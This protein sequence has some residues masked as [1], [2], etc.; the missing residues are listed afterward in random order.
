MKTSYPLVGWLAAGVL[1]IAGGPWIATPSAQEA[2][3]VVRH[4]ERLNDSADSPLSAAG[5]ARAARLADHLR[6]ARIT[7][8]VVTQFVRTADTAQPLAD[9]LGLPLTL[10]PAAQTAVLVARLRALGPKARVLVVGHSNT[11][12]DILTALG[13]SEPVTIAPEDFANLFVVLPRAAAP[14]TVIRIQY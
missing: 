13:S 5:L 7:S 2:V 11:V 8:I 1:V 14:P 9:R 12:P 4:A 6:D 3:F 10:V